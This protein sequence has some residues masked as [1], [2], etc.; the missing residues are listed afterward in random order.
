MQRVLKFIQAE[1]GERGS[2]ASRGL[3]YVYKGEQ[4]NRLKMLKQKRGKLKLKV[5][6][7]NLSMNNLLQ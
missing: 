7:G 3:G 2:V 6:K 1:D 5:M 4:R